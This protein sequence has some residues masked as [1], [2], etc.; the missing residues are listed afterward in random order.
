MRIIEQQRAGLVAQGDAR[1]QSIEVGRDDEAEPAGAVRCLE[2]R[3]A[4]IEDVPGQSAELR[5]ILRDD[6]DRPNQRS[7][8]RVRGVGEDSQIE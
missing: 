3:G 2:Q 5:G 4:G 1:R 7:Q 8:H 6:V